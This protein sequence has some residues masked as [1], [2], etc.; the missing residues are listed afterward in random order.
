MCNFTLPPPYPYTEG[1]RNSK[2]KYEAKLEFLGGGVAFGHSPIT[3]FRKGPK[4]R[5]SCD[6]RGQEQKIKWSG[7]LKKP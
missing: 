2:G 3:S 7:A 5:N 1:I 4:R 6:I